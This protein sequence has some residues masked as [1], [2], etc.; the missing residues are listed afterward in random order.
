[1]TTSSELYRLKL[2]LSFM[3]IRDIVSNCN[4]FIRIHGHK[5]KGCDD[6][7]EKRGRFVSTNPN[8]ELP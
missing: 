4:R 6:L 7:H 5:K 2:Q 8:A 1:M 3:T